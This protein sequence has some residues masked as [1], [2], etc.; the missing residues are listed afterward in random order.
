MPVNHGKHVGIPEG[1]L[2]PTG[3]HKY[4]EHRAFDGGA[5]PG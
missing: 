3:N 1:E 5:A 2:N 4:R